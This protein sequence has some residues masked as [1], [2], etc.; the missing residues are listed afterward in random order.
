MHSQCEKTNGQIEMQKTL[1][2]HHPLNIHKTE[3]N[4]EEE[5]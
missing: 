2:S 4:V 3:Q 5:F 1:E